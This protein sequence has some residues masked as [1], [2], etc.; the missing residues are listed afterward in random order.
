MAKLRSSHREASVLSKAQDYIRTHVIFPS[1]LLGIILLVAA[2]MGLAY[3]YLAE[4]YQPSTFLQSTGLAVVGALAGWGHSRYQRYLLANF[5]DALA[6]KLDAFLKK[7]VTRAKKHGPKPLDHPGRSWMPLVYVLVILLLLGLAFSA[8]A[9][10]TVYPVAAYLLPAAGFFCA[11][12]YAWKDLWG[13]A[14]SVSSRL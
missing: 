3:Q 13:P 1:A 11:R 5:P 2:T 10:G 7:D 4:T 8:G 6:A 12:V 14:S 9:W